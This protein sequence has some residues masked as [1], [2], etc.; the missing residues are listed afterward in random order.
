[1]CCRFRACEAAP[2]PA[3]ADCSEGWEVEEDKMVSRRAILSRWV[4]CH[5]RVRSRMTLSAIFW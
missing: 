3:P 1:M 2:F 5:S 4:H